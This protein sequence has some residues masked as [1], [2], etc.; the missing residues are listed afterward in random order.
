MRS[1]CYRV[2]EQCCC[3]CAMLLGPISIPS[4]VSR[5][6]SYKTIS[7]HCTPWHCRGIV[8]DLCPCRPAGFFFSRGYNYKA[9][10]RNTHPCITLHAC[11]SPITHAMLVPCYT[12]RNFVKASGPHVARLHRPHVAWLQPFFTERVH[13]CKINKLVI[14]R[15]EQD[16]NAGGQGAQQSPSPTE[17]RWVLRPVSFAAPHARSNYVTGYMNK[18]AMD[19]GIST[20]LCQTWCEILLGLATFV[21]IRGAFWTQPIRSGNESYV[22]KGS[23][24]TIY[25]ATY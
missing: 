1:D 11:S 22:L 12:P 23:I 14:T 2:C 5:S 18:L 6:D 24:Q 10:A 9:S 17:L 8:E 19:S 16:S 20:A 3:C 25:S 4:V 13:V 7:R 21:A 15:A